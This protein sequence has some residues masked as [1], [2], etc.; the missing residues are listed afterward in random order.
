[1]SKVTFGLDDRNL[2]R[3]G[4]NFDGDNFDKLIH[5][6]N[7]HIILFKNEDGNYYIDLRFPNGQM[8]S[9]YFEFVHQL[10]NF[11]FSIIGQELDFIEGF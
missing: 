10:Q 9:V 2:I 1:M 7:Q 6:E 4:F 5:N 8:I 3:L 11:Y